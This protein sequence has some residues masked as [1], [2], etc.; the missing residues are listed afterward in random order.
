MHIVFGKSAFD[1]PFLNVPPVRRARRVV[2]VQ[3]GT[4]GVALP[5]WRST[6]R[7]LST[8]M[9]GIVFSAVLWMLVAGPGFLS[10][11]DSV[12]PSQAARADHQVSR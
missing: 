10:A 6:L 11:R 9:Q 5:D 1:V 8:A 4:L 7:V 2:H 3:R 12:V